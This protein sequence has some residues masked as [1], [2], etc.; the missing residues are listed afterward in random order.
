M[1]EDALIA[2]TLAL[3]WLGWHLHSIAAD[4]RHMRR[5]IKD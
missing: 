2:M 3:I 5:K 4:I 1:S